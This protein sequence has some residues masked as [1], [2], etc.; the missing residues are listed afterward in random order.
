MNI[1]WKN[2]R[3]L[4]TGG[5]GFIGSHVVK[6]LVK[7][8]SK[9]TIVISP[10]TSIVHLKLLYGPILDL[11]SVKKADLLV[12]TQF[13]KVTK[14]QEIVLNFAALDGGAEFKQINETEI[15][16]INTQL[17]L[18]LLESS[19]INKIDR[20]LIMSSIDIYPNDLKFPI[21][22]E[23]AHLNDFVE[24]ISGYRWSKRIAEIAA[25][26]Y[27]RKYGLKIAIVRAGNV[28]GEDDYTGI[29]KKRIIPTFINA[30]LE[31]KDIIIWGNT[32]LKKSYLYISDLSKA[33]LDAIE[34]YPVG[35]PINI[36]SSEYVSLID[37]VKL[38]LKLTHGK[39]KI[40]HKI[41]TVPI[42]GL[43]KQSISSNKALR[44]LGWKPK[45]SLAKGL[46]KT[47]ESF[48]S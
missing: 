38:I 16:R 31:D 9:V 18:N 34:K 11:I 44:V 46:Q 35:E 36:A 22:E 19:R 7:R 39:S 20:V 40:I 17:I 32:D 3:V 26:L 13:L 30:A 15:F 12:F 41:S 1:F 10:K 28:Y 6:E 4:V 25:N 33:L 43:F 47:I 27:Y 5:A 42:K 21:K 23:H 29:A 24:N 14:T 2:K 48:R 8:E 45:I 37:L